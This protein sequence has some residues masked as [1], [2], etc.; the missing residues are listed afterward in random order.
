[1]KRIL[2]TTSSFGKNDSGL[3][4]K[5]ESSGYQVVLNPYKRKLTEAE[6]TGLIVENQ[7]VG[8]IAGVEP[9]TRK[10]LE[11]A[12]KLKAISR[13]GIGMD[14]VDL[15]AAKELKI[16]VTN[17][18]DAPTVP[19][20]ELAVG[21]IL[22]LLRRIHISDYSVRQKE[23]VRPMGN[24]L[25]GKTLGIVGC[26]RIGSCV[27]KLLSGFDC[28]VIG[29]D[30]LPVDSKLVSIVEL[31]F[32]LKTADIVSLHMPYS[33]DNHYFINQ[34]KMGIMKKGAFLINAGRGGLVDESALLNALDSGHLAGAALDCFEKEPYNGPLACSDKVLLTAHIGSYASEGRIMMERQAVENILKIL[35]NLG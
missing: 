23:W 18:P 28:K 34:D 22:S 16:K 21:M 6:V 29:Y 8:I 2:V 10:V 4:P 25:N 20:A 13:A 17:T 31:D 5:L 15:D 19:V 11:R 3:L 33:S 24:L 7:P 32:L 12:S 9:L 30:P 26:G 14:S 35:N 1:M 27:A